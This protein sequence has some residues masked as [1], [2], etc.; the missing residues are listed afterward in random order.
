MVAQ[1]HRFIGN[2]L[3]RPSQPRAMKSPY[4]AIQVPIRT[5]A[6]RTRGREDRH[7]GQTAGAGRPAQHRRHG[8]GQR[9]DDEMLMPEQ[10]ELVVH[11]KPL[12]CVRGTGAQRASVAIW[13]P[14]LRC[15]AG[16]VNSDNTFIL[17][18]IMT[19]TSR[20]WPL[21]WAFP[22]CWPW[23]RWRRRMRQRAPSYLRSSR[24]P[25]ISSRPAA[26]TAPIFWRRP[27]KAFDELIL[28]S[29]PTARMRP[30]P[31]PH[32]KS[33]VTA[34]GRVTRTLYVAPQAARRS[35]S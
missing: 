21:G 11:R 15:A 29:G 16:A 3:P 17:G 7:V 14:G 25:A 12:P 33:T 20:A 35:R 32:F 27:F 30:T 4:Q 26:M 19:P 18:N 8:E 1:S 2:S 13:W 28:P 31:R 5:A 9:H 10:D 22:D 34:Q 24:A 6:E 23:P